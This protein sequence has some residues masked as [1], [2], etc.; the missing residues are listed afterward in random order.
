MVSAALV[1][2]FMGAAGWITLPLGAVPV[3]LQVFGVLLAALLLTWEWALAALGLYLVMGAAG[4]PV[5][6]MG[7]AGMGVVLGP[8]GG[9]L[10][11]FVVAA[12]AGAAMR[13]AL[14][15]GRAKQ[16]VADAIAAVFVIAVIYVCGW[17]QL[18][19]VT[20]MGPAKALAVGVVPFLVPDAIKAAVAL[21]IASA[22]RKSGVRL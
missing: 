8:T 18:S 11:G 7:T 22:V 15:R 16:I 6:A 2:A 3:T 14:E 13:V 21:T 17:L 20:G 1:T 19:A 10:S 5:F 12:T 9:Y 4:V